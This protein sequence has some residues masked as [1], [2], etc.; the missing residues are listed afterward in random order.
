M[1]EFICIGYDIREWPCNGYY[2]VDSTEWEVSEELFEKAKTE[3]G[4]YSNHF[5]LLEILTNDDLDRLVKFVAAV[6][7]ATLVSVEAPLLVVN[8]LRKYKEWGINENMACGDDWTKLGYDVCDANGFFSIL[9]MEQFQ[10]QERSMFKEDRLS[11][12]LILAQAANY[13]V[14]THAPFI[15]VNLKRIDG[16]IQ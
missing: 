11:E 13:I 16:D 3:V 7:S 9:H 15:V 1:L 5:Q 4:T 14:P 8:A 12:A 10:N 6:P 2:T